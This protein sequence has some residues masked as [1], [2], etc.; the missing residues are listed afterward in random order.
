MK[1]I[2]V[3]LNFVK[4]TNQFLLDIKVR[5]KAKIRNQYN[6]IPHLTQDTIWESD[7]NTRK[8]SHT[9]TNNRK[10]PQKKHRLGTVSKKENYWRASTCLMVP[11]SPLFLIWIKTDRWFAWKIPYLCIKQDF[12]FDIYH[13]CLIKHHDVIF[14][15]EKTY[16]N[17]MQTTM[18]YVNFCIL[19]N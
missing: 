4:W 11:T 12:P 1:Q 18:V 19:H 13:S 14:C 17:H 2:L 10:D 8:T 3:V 7:K 16:L 6:Q 5:K 15:Y 9:N